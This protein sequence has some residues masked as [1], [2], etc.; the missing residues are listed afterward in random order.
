MLYL[1]SVVCSS[2]KGFDVAPYQI[3]GRKPLRLSLPGPVRAQG[4]ALD[5]AA[6][7]AGDL[8][9]AG[10]RLHASAALQPT[11]AASAACQ[12]CRPARS[13]QVIPGRPEVPFTAGRFH[14]P[15][16]INL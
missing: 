9:Q 12:G 1:D 10:P 5:V 2:D 13:V 11:D 16:N 8:R 6:P 15:I 4:G 14:G 3:G 7:G